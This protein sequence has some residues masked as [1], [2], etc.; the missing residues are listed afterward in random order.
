LE[1]LE[2]ESLTGPFWFGKGQIAY[3]TIYLMRIDGGATRL[4]KTFA[5]EK[6]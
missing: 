4:Q 6:K 3:R 5:P 2:A 1:K